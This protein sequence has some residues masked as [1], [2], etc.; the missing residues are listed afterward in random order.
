MQAEGDG[1]LRSMALNNTA[2]PVNGWEALRQRILELVGSGGG[3][4]SARE[5]AEVEIDCDYNL[6]YI[7]VID[8]I[9]AVLDILLVMGKW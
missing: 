1:S 8:A 9:T 2:L 5:S 4:G 3:P 6:K 7:Y